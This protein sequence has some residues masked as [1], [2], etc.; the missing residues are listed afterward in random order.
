[1]EKSTESQR[2]R[3]RQSQSR[4]ELSD[5][6]EGAPNS[7][8][9]FS[10]AIPTLTGLPQEARD[11]ILSE[12][13]PNR[14]FQTCSDKLC[15]PRLLGDCIVLRN[16][17]LLSIRSVNHDLNEQC[18]V[19]MYNNNRV[20]IDPDKFYISLPTHM[21]TSEAD[22][23][24]SST[25]MTEIRNIFITDKHLRTYCQNETILPFTGV[26]TINIEHDMTKVPMNNVNLVRHIVGSDHLE[27][28]DK[29]SLRSEIM[30]MS[31][32]ELNALHEKVWSEEKGKCLDLGELLSGGF[33][34]G[35]RGLS[36]HVHVR[37]PKCQCQEC[38]WMRADPEGGDSTVTVVYDWNDQVVLDTFWV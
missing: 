37:C 27:L 22:S 23:I 29:Q 20:Y 1:M 14:D 15:N 16:G 5:S 25:M 9:D 8:L 12:I 36:I 24:L 31:I 33:E 13:L 30:A 32:A 38:R 10:N 11:L 3:Q 17:T 21:H 7:I 6:C 4:L 28:S 2:Q 19:Y 35:A 18:L 26:R 34:H